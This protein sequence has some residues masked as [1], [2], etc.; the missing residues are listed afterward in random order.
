MNEQDR[1]ERDESPE[2][3]APETCTQCF[4]RE[5]QTL[6]QGPEALLPHPMQESRHTS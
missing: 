4:R 1:Q 3:D 2:T 5:M 6:L